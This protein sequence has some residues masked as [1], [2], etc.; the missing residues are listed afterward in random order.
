MKALNQPVEMIAVCSPEGELCPARFRVKGED[1]QLVTV[2]IRRIR[3]REE[4]P[5]YGVEMFRYVCSAVLGP[6]E[7][8][9]ELRYNVRSHRWVLW[10]FLDGSGEAVI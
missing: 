1:G 6:R 10:R 5:Y 8:L 3:D 7:R 2:R 4:I 9:F